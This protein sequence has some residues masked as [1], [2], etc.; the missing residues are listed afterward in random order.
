VLVEGFG[1][2]ANV[3]RDWWIDARLDALRPSQSL[4]CAVETI[5]DRYCSRTV[6]AMR[7]EGVRQV[8]SCGSVVR[9][10]QSQDHS[11]NMNEAAS[12]LLRKGFSKRTLAGGA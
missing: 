8:V 2:G 7:V 11:P 12:L 4:D 9:M 1:E 10:M 6:E 5:F 3:C